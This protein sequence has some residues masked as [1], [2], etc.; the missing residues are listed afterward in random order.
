M[1]PVVGVNGVKAMG[2][3]AARRKTTMTTCIERAHYILTDVTHNNNK[4]W[5]IE[6]DAD[7]TVRT[8]WGR[9]GDDG[10]SKT[11]PGAG[12]G[13]FQAK[14]REKQGKGYKPVRTVEAVSGQS[15]A[16]SHSDVA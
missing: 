3:Q 5:N 6:M 8:Y 13:F 12:A 10:Q 4:F 7:G 14:C 15:R 2:R 16:L 1:I 9:V 11:F